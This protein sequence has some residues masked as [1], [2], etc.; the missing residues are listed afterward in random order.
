M[1]AVIAERKASPYHLI[2]LNDLAAAA[3]QRR[4]ISSFHQRSVHGSPGHMHAVSPPLSQLGV[5]T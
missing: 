1:T 3:G 5:R 2:H 4:Q